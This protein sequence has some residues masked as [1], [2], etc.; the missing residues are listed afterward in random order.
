MVR[1]SY[2]VKRGGYRFLRCILWSKLVFGF[3]PILLLIMG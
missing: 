2:H 3:Y 1:R